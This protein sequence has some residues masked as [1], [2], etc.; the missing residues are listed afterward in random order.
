M[1]RYFQPP[2]RHHIG[3]SV[4]ILNLSF[5]KTFSPRYQSAAGQQDQISSF[6]CGS[7]GQQIGWVGEK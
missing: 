6:A 3:T 1:K 5:E 4:F 7:E 2:L